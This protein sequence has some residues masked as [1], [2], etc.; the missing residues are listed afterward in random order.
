MDLGALLGGEL[1][2]TAD[3]LLGL[4]DGIV[5]L[6]DEGL[7]CRLAVAV[8]AGTGVKGAALGVLHLFVTDLFVI[9]GETP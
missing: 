3:I 1:W 7:A 4:Q 9:H 2:L 8:E 5:T 6:G